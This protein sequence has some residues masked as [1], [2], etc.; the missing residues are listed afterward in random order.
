MLGSSF[1]DSIARPVKSVASSAMKLCGSRPVFSGGICGNASDR[2]QIIQF[3]GKI[4]TIR[5]C[6]ILDM[7]YNTTAD[8]Y[9]TG[10]E[11]HEWQS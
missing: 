1:S 6:Q 8:M 7:A 9:E 11:W 3:Y 4:H 10:E 2:D 5:H